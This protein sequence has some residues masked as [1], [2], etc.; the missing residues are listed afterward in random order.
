VV[1]R[2]RKVGHF[3]PGGTVDAFDVW[4]ELEAVDSNGRPVFHSGFVEDGGKGP[5][6]PG[7]HFYRSL[8]LDERGNPIN[9][10]NAWATRS[11]AYVRLIPPG[12]ADTVHYRLRIPEDCG[13]RIRLR[14][15]LNYRKFAWW[16]TQFS[17]A[18]V[19]DSAHQGYSVTPG[20]DDGRWIFTG[21]TSGVSGKVKAIPDLPITVMAEA[22]A[23]IRV[24]AKDA[25]EPPAQAALDPSVRERWNDYGIGLLLQGDLKGAEAAFLKVTQAEPGYADGWVN[26]GRARLT[27]GNLEGAEE[28][29]RKALAIDPGLAKTHFFLG[30]MLKQDGR[31]DEAL[32]H[33]RRA[34]ALYPRD[35]VVRNQIGRVLFL[36]RR[37]GEAIGELRQV[38][39]IDPED[40]QAH[41]NLMLSYQGAGEPDMAKKHE[42]LYRR[43][44]ADEAAQEITGPY[45]R[46]HP[47]D[48]N[49]RQ[50]VH[51][52]VS[53]FGPPAAGTRYAAARPRPR[54]P[55]ASATSANASGSGGAG[56]ETARVAGARRAAGG[57]R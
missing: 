29:L 55:G 40:L 2:T 12:A 28:M 1:V 56:A 21:D 13:D 6:E 41:Y 39:A 54:A 5:V 31:Y 36:E 15:K 45:R 34:A 10:R 38:L 43:F 50:A 9:K 20:H 11:V 26:V 3:F 32:G 22:A 24:L 4:V 18:G 44:K 47:H 14:A 19:R 37:F 25:P 30:S 33:L 57:T 8:M 52:H 35:R 23:E 53:P 17:F 51:E 48:N 46:L 16:N 49:E 7:A 27:E 42:A